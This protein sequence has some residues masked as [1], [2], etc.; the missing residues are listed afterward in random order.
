MIERN[1]SHFRISLTEPPTSPHLHQPCTALHPPCPAEKKASAQAPNEAKRN[2]R[3][4][5]RAVQQPQAV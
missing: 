5:I 3:S 4:H 1:A 2:A